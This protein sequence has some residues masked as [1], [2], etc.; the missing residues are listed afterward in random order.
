[1]YRRPYLIL[2][3]PK[4]K[5][6]IKELENVSGVPGIEKKKEKKK[7]EKKNTKH[8]NRQEGWSFLTKGSILHEEEPE[9]KWDKR[10]FYWS[11][12]CIPYAEITSMWQ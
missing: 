4:Y 5:L 7:G 12:K 6:Y 11:L 2:Y 9:R 10:V 8:K 3:R 1:M